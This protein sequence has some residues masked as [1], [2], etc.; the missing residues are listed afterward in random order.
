MKKTILLYLFMVLFL[1]GCIPL[2]GR[3]P[4]TIMGGIYTMSSQNFEV[5]LPEGWRRHNFTPDALLITLDGLSLQQICIA[6]SPI[7]KEIPYTQ[8]KFSKGM[9]PQE[10]AEVVID[11]MRFNPNIM[12][13]KITENIP[14][15][16]SNYSGFKLIYS[17]QTN[18]GLKKKSIYY[19]FM[20]E[21]WYYGLLY[22][23]PARHYFEKDLP[24]FERVKESFRILKDAAS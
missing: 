10:V 23:A 16:I 5:E 19:G 7:D 18:G 20:M 17:Y 22:D 3:A 9:L 13:L 1:G 21:N 11:H 4:W 12:N 2:E 6:R 14:A 8:K 15:R 24:T